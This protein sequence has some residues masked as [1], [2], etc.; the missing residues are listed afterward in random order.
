ME[1]LI[2]IYPEILDRTVEH[3]Y[4]TAVPIGAA[5]L[6]GIPV[7]VILTRKIFISGKVLGAA[8]VI[9]TI[10]SLAMIGFMIPLFGIGVPA[11]LVALYLYSLLPIL[12]NT[13]TG[14][15]GVDKAVIEAG[16]GMGMTDHQ[17]LMKV[18][19]PLAVPVIMAGIRTATV[20]VVGIATL[21]GIMG[22]GGLGNLI[23]QGIAMVNSDLILAGAIPAAMLA[24]ALDFLLGKAERLLSPGR[25]GDKE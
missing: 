20:I 7:G 6:T 22:A 24:L 14:I 2:Q 3:L 1:F 11:A 23:F 25:K 19:L 10:P 17:L 12:R 5:A 4:L 9:Q 18:Q 8:S 15:N 21:A 13:F 16:R